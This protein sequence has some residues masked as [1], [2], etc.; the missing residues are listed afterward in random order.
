MQDEVVCVKK[1]KNEN[2]KQKKTPKSAQDHTNLSSNGTES[3]S[4]LVTIR[5]WCLPNVC[6]KQPKASKSKHKQATVSKSKQYSQLEFKFKMSSTLCRAN[7]RRK[8]TKASESKHD[9]L[10]LLSN[11]NSSWPA[12]KSSA[13]PPGTL[14]R[15]TPNPPKTHLKPSQERPKSAQERPEAPTSVQERAKSGQQAPQG[16][17][18]SAQVLPEPSSRPPQMEPNSLQKLIF[19]PFC[20]FRFSTRIL[21]RFYSDFSNIFNVSIP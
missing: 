3:A 20:R 21:C 6:I 8:Q 14:P 12:A 9:H 19:T 17:R 2:K 15:P 13:N 16:R 1:S 18:K 7:A 11:L 10:E 5:M 4:S